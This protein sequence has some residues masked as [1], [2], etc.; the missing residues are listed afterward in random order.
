M[1]P[2]TQRISKSKSHLRMRFSKMPGFLMKCDLVVEKEL[3]PE[4]NAFRKM[5]A[6][7]NQLKTISH[8]PSAKML[9]SE[10]CMP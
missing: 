1:L 7:V 6:G 3:D 10:S 8:H 2:Q 5:T 4:R 9:D